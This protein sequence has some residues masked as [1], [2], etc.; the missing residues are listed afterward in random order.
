MINEEIEEITK[1]HE[2]VWENFEQAFNTKGTVTKE[3]I[4]DVLKAHPYN[5]GF[6]AYFMDS[7]SNDFS[8]D[9]CEVICQIVENLRSLIELLLPLASV[10]MFAGDNSF[11]ELRNYLFDCEKIYELMQLNI[12]QFAL[13]DIA[14][15]LGGEL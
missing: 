13:D 6:M 4:I 15:A 12:I 8:K 3:E 10:P 9:A 11:F 1:M 5:L 7:F 2:R 14:N